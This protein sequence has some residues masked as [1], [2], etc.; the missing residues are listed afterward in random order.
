M[1]ISLVMQ[2]H[3][4]LELTRE[5]GCNF[6]RKYPNN[7]TLDI[8]LITSLKTVNLKYIILGTIIVVTQKLIQI[9]N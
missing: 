8:M 4:A 9:T 5:N 2:H 1:L 6:L 3:G 7:K